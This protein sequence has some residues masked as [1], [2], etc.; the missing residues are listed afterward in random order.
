MESIPWQ[1]PVSGDPLQLEIRARHPTGRPHVG[2]LVRKQEDIGYPIVDG[3][4]RLTPDLAHEYEDW[5]PSGVQPPGSIEVEQT[6]ES[7][8]SFG[9]QW[10]W[11]GDA[12]TE[13]DLQWRVADRFGLP[14]NF[15]EG[16]TVLDAGCGAGD[17]SRW[18]LDNGADRLI[19]LDLSDAIEVTYEKLEG[20]EDWVGV[21]G[22]VSSLPFSP[23]SFDFVYCEGVIQHTQDSELTTKELLRVL[24]VEGQLAATHYFLPDDFKLRSRT[25][26][27]QILRKRLSDLD[28][29]QLLFV[30][31]L[32][33][34]GTKV[35]IIG[36]LWGKTVAVQNPRM[37]SFKRT[38]VD[39][40]DLYG[41]QDFQRHIDPDVFISFFDDSAFGLEYQENTT[42]LVRRENH[43]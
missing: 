34:A 20:R 39:T 11:A 36:E 38:W 9:F 26:L 23:Y 3:I 18:M 27:R 19:S 13:N 42:V 40:F 43:S 37:P 14:E 30:T 10:A 2:A 1:D 32:L 21:Q 24:D 33:A 16:R 6:G 17:Q 29:E 12:R 25:K 22:D 35:P 7:V 28:R 8:E 4:P 15:F 41:Q 5:L 31:G